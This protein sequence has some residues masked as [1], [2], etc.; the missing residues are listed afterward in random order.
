MDASMV[1][2][3]TPTRPTRRFAED[4]LGDLLAWRQQGLRSALVTLVDLDGSGPRPVGS[5][6]AVN[7]LG[8]WAGQI[9]SGCA[10][11]QLVAHAV[12]AIEDGRPRLERYGKGSKYFDIQLPCGSGIEVYF[13]PLVP[14]SIVESVEVARAAR[15]PVALE[16]RA[17]EGGSSD[18]ALRKLDIGGPAKQHMQSYGAMDADG[19]FTRRY[20]PS[21]RIVMAGR[22]PALEA[23]AS[24]AAVLGWSVVAASPDQDALDA[25]RPIADAVQPLAKP[26]SFDASVIDRW[27]ASVLLFHDH[28]WEPQIVSR[29]LQAEG[30]YIGALGSRQTHRTRRE[31][32]KALGLSA[33]DIE[34]VRGPIGLDIGARNPPELALSIAGEILATASW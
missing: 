14:T 6:M 5:Q 24:F 28:D 1:Q 8:D 29:M 20:L 2:V 16:F 10:E 25:I 4:V 33:R 18:H 7:E 15:Q 23:L 30:F 19:V 22:G 34:K 13:D 21:L 12:E 11:A 27:T 9:T 26:E 17:A 3:N 32:L 31:A